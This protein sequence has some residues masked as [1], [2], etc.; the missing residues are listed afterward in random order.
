MSRPGASSRLLESL[1]PYAY[2]LHLDGAELLDSPSAA[3]IAGW[4]ERSRR[5]LTRV[6]EW[7]EHPELLS[8]EN[9]E[10]WDP[11]LFAPLLDEIPVSRVVDVGHLWL[12]GIDPLPHLERWTGRSRVI[13][14]H[15]IAERDHSSLA[16]VSADLLDPVVDVLGRRFTGVVTLEVFSL[17]DFMTSM[18]ALGTFS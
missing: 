12:Q 16:G 8:I 14:L 6:G 1:D 10:G 5:A 9:V 2:T 3:F 17:D 15:G 11:E 13:H 4:Q 18:E 7:L